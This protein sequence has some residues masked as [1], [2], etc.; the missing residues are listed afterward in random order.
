MAGFNHYPS[1]VERPGGRAAGSRFDEPLSR[2]S[3][4]FNTKDT[5]ARRK[6]TILRVGMYMTNRG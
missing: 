1:P 4:E 5:H 6:N 2:P 3:S